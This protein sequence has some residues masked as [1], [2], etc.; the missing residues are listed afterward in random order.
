M[1]IF[2]LPRVLQLQTS[3]L[4][5]V[6]PLLRISPPRQG[7]LRRCHV[8]HS[9]RPRLPTGKGSGAATHLTVSYEPRASSIKKG[10][11]SLAMQL[12]S[13]VP[14]ARSCD[15]K[16]PAPEQLWLARSVSMRHH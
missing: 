11:T 7:G 2:A 15:F 12:G 3:P 1:C 8:S 6:G 13:C 14:N 10:L 9:T 4:Y 5:R 16:A